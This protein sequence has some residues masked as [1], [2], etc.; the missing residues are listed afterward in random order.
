MGTKTGA[1]KCVHDQTIRKSNARYRCQCCGST[2]RVTLTPGTQVHRCWTCRPEIHHTAAPWYR[3]PMT[4]FLVGAPQPKARKL[5]P[6]CTIEGECP[7]CN[8]KIRSRPVPYPSAARQSCMYD[9]HGDSYV[10]CGTCMRRYFH[11]N[12]GD[13]LSR[14][15]ISDRT[16]WHSDRQLANV[17]VVRS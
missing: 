9:K 10:A 1:Q 4:E 16:G 15:G 8:T 12:E 6:D 7:R 13:S 3:G 11:Y 14:L 17:R 5:P 2:D